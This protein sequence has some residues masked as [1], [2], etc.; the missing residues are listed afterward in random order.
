MTNRVSFHCEHVVDADYVYTHRQ[1]DGGRITVVDR[2]TGFGWRD[3]ETGYKSPC[4]KFWLAS[5]HQ[6]IRDVLDELSSDEE[7]AAWV[8]ERANNCVASAPYRGYNYA[9]HDELMRWERRGCAGG[10]KP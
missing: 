8:I 5:G 9:T 1:P 7:M 4:G 6:D 2:M 10:A 3:F